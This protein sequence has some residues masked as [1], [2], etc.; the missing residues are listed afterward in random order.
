MHPWHDIELGKDAPG[1]VKVV[2]EIAKGSRCKYELHKPTGMLMLD[3]VLY[4]A[5]HYPANY[6][7]VP[8]TYYL[9]NDP[10]DIV[11]ICSEEL[12]PLSIL[13]ARVI[14]VMHMEDQSEPDD[15]IIAVAA[16]DISLDH[17][18]DIGDLPPHTEHELR[19]F[20]EDYKKLENKRV[21][22]LGFKGRETALKIISESIDRYQQEIKPKLNA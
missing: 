4:S 8:Q 15:K 6:G 18:K 16:N 12:I 20:F 13:D 19:N 1:I 22:V 14:G 3:R 17:I 2:I 21:D 5:V 7:L 9:D 10:L 11:V